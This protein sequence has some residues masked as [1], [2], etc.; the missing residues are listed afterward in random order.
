MTSAPTLDLIKTTIE[1]VEPYVSSGTQAL[2]P[3]IPPRPITADIIATGA[4][5]PSAATISITSEHYSQLLDSIR[6]LASDEEET[7]RP[8]DFALA[9]AD[10]LLTSAAEKLAL[11]FPA[12]YVTVGPA[13]SLRISWVDRERHVRLICGGSTENRSY[14]YIEHGERHGIA[15]KVTGDVLAASLLWMMMS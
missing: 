2:R 5:E 9:L 15:E 1:F 13:G 14:I 7:D 8:T 10:A 6:S 11:D 12:A 4:Q 3:G